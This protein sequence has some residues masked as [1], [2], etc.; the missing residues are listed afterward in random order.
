MKKNNYNPNS[1][2]TI[3]NFGSTVYN[4]NGKA[5]FVTEHPGFDNI[6]KMH[7]HTESQSEFETALNAMGYK[8]KSWNEFYNENTDQYEV[9]YFTDIPFDMYEGIMKKIDINDYFDYYQESDSDGRNQSWDLWILRLNVP[10]IVQET[11]LDEQDVMERVHDDGGR[12]LCDQMQSLFSQAVKDR[13]G[14]Y[15]TTDVD[16]QKTWDEDFIELEIK[17]SLSI[18]LNKLYEEVAGNK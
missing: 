5:V 17:R 3:V 4:E 9:R 6:E 12:Y 15:V 18:F 16:E 8:L 10:K 11:G 2:S 7:K 14:W 13:D 1:I